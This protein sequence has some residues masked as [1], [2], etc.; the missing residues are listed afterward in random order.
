MAARAA[1]GRA[2]AEE[3]ET[4]RVAGATTAKAEAV[5]AVGWAAVEAA[6]ARA[7]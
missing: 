1:A 2:A 7:A 6:V 4:A 5:S 3:E